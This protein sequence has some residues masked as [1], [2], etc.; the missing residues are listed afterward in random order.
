MDNYGVWEELPNE[1]YVIGDIHGDFFALK[2][3]LELTNCV[4]FDDYNDKFK[5]NEEYEYYYLDD[6]CNYYSI[7]KNNVCWNK[8][9]IN[10]F[11]VFS[12]DLIDR[13]RPNNINNHECINTVS[14]ENCDYL[15]LNF[16]YELDN[17]AKIYNSRVLVILG[18]HEIMN[19]QYNFK[20]VSRKG[21]NDKNRI[22]NINKYLKNNILNV[23]GII[24]INKYIIVH[25]GINDKFFT[26][27]NKI[28]NYNNLES[29]QLFNNELRTFI[30]TSNS[31]FI[32]DT[33]LNESPFWDRTLGGFDYLNPNQC[34]EI[35]HN[36]LLNIKN[37]NNDIKIIVAHCPQFNVNK[38]INL[39][40]CQEYENKIWRIDVG[41]S[42]GFD[43]YDMNKIKNILNTNYKEILNINY[44]DFF[45][46]DN[47]TENRKVSILKL[48]QTNEEILKGITTIDYFYDLKIF[49]NNNYIRLLHIL[50][51][52]IKIYINN[53]NE[54]FDPTEQINYFLYIIKLKNIIKDIFVNL[55]LFK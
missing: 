44:K 46:I 8:N 29:I 20:Y 31:I 13:C 24:R 43:L 15:L 16:L 17:Q 30:L 18:N 21:R 49:N 33:N 5:L 38:M 39:V 42:R 34:Y 28:D 26:D 1:L 50:C 6:G 23:Y 2:Q 52:L 48:T 54:N 4:K 32:N 7:T 35:F 55:S 22:E 40:N 11:I 36:N 37:N 45:I 51:D 3:S 9:K 47:Q 19:L 41:M 10:C 53:Y 12:G 25:G 27:F 14:D